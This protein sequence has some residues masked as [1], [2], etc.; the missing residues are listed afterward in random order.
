MMVTS[1]VIMIGGLIE[2]VMA[3]AMVMAVAFIVMTVMW[4]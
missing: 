4:L 2:M 1:M 3:M